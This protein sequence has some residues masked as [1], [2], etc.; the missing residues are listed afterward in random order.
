M[1]LRFVARRSVAGAT[2]GGLRIFPVLLQVGL[3]RRWSDVFKSCR[4]HSG[5]WLCRPPG[6]WLIRSLDIDCRAGLVFGG[7]LNRGLPPA[8]TV[9]RP[10]AADFPDII[11]GWIGASM[12]GRVQIM[13][14]A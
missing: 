6:R 1:C 4:S 11:E 7:A 2:T 5:R 8:A 14:I 13:P 10:P 9:G 3:A 12:V